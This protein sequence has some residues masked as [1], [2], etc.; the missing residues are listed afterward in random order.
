MLYFFK[1]II[2]NG[3]LLKIIAMLAIVGLAVSD[4]MALFLTFASDSM[5]VEPSDTIMLC[6][7]LAICLEGLPAIAGFS[8]AKFLDNTKYRSN[9]FHLA[10][11]GTIVAF[12]GSFLSFTAVVFLRGF[13]IMQK[14]S[15]LNAGIADELNLDSVSIIEGY[16]RGKYDRFPFDLFMTIYP[17]ITSVFSFAISWMLLG[18]ENDE[19]VKEVADLLH[20]EY[21][22][23]TKQFQKKLSE[24]QDAR[25]DLWTLISADIN[26][27]ERFIESY[28]PN[29]D[30][31]IQE[32]IPRRQDVF[33]N[34]C[35]RRM[36]SKLIENCL[37]LYP[38]QIRLYNTAVNQR[39]QLYI[40][41]MKD[42]S[43]VPEEIETIDVEQIIA[44]YDS[45][46]NSKWRYDDV[47]QEMSA[48]L[49][50]RL[51]NKVIVQQ[52]RIDG[53]PEPREGVK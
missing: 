32:S 51:N 33:K 8:L 50:K 48:N 7:I 34:Y 44:K 19:A 23:R 53:H 47:V 31:K 5:D 26:L 39:L 15:I 43:T 41:R 11:M 24:L 13:P 52:I 46:R 35:Y 38:E 2:R 16:L 28:D 12:L 30:K 18:R 21:M 36:R 3:T 4:Y 45:R 22:L 37:A 49:A 9:A 40:T 14:M 6:V 42:Y 27:P 17:F 29:N 20:D 25:D 1:K 10:L